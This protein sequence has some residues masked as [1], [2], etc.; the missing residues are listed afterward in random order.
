MLW[1]D[2]KDTLDVAVALVVVSA[3]LAKDADM[4][5][6]SQGGVDKFLHYCYFVTPCT[7]NLPNKI[8]TIVARC[9]TPIIASSEHIKANSSEILPGAE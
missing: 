8:R 4:A 9:P 7:V 3:E 2:L 6:E 5:V 1:R